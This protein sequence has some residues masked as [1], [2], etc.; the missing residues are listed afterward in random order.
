MAGTS[1]LVI[2]LTAQRRLLIVATHTER[3]RAMAW[4]KD[5]SSGA[6]FA[7]ISID[8][9]SL[10]ARGVCIGGEPALYRLDYDLKTGPNFVTSHL[11]VQCCGDRWRRRLNLRRCAQGGWSI[12]ATAEGEIG[13]PPPGGDVAQLEAALDCDL[14]LSPLTNSMPICRHGLMHGG[15]PID[16]LM[17]WVAVPALSVQGDRQRYSHVATR[18]LRHVVRY[19]ALEG[20]FAA[21]IVVDD[22]GV[23]VDYPGIARALCV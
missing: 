1:V 16:F 17:A 10:T 6:E 2:A 19:E 7:E 9:E 18:G 8:D 4:L 5:E 22:D 23:V 14:G 11:R 20:G 3:R 21:D 12:D 15:G 13:L